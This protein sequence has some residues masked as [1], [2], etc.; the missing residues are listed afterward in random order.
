MVRKDRI[1]RRALLIGAGG[2]AAAAIG[3]T[4]AERLLHHAPEGTSVG[5]GCGIGDWPGL[6]RL[7]ENRDL[8]AVTDTR[9]VLKGLLRDHLGIDAATLDRK[10]FP[11]APGLKP[12]DGLVR[13]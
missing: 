1:T 4:L 13:A 5:A 7:E 11:N 6:D 2:V 8:R 9:S 10:V 12:M 3:A